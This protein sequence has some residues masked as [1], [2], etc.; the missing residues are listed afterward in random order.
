MGSCPATPV[1]KGVSSMQQI[2]FEECGGKQGFWRREHWWLCYL[3]H[4]GN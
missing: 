3:T 1:C 2:I 4:Y